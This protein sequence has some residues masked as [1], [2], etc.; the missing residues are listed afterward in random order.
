MNNNAI[1]IPPAIWEQDQD[2]WSAWV[3]QSNASMKTIA[4]YKRIITEFYY[5][6]ERPILEC[7]EAD[8]S[9]YERADGLFL[10]KSTVAQ[11]ASVI[12]R[13]WTFAKLTQP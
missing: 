1:A 10:A 5:A 12:R 3:A 4:Q 7:T 6:M 13:Y 8:L 2:I 9:F 11:R